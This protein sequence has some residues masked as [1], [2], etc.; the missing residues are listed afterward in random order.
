MSPFLEQEEF[1]E[2]MHASFWQTIPAPQSFALHAPL[3]VS[4]VMHEPQ[5]TRLSVQH[6]VLLTQAAPQSF[7]PFGHAFPQGVS[8]PMHVSPQARKPPL[9]LRPQVPF[10]HTAT[11]FEGAGQVVHAGPHAVTLVSDSQRFVPHW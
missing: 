7:D 5:P 11:P 10:W 6:V 1:D 9:H 2:H 4:Q 3:L 8:G